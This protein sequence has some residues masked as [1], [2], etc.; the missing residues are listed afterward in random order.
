MA[1]ILFTLGLTVVLLGAGVWVGVALGFSGIIGLAHVLGIDRAVHIAGTVVWEQNTSFVLVAIPMFIFMGEL[2]FQSGVMSKVYLRAATVVSGIPGALLQ[3]NIAAC[4]IF[5]A[6][7]GSSVASAATIGSVGYPEISKRGYDKPI[8][9]GSIAAG[10]TLGILIPPSII[11]IV[12]GSL[13]EVSVG[14]LFLAGVIPGLALAA[15]YSAYIA[16]RCLIDPALAPREGRMGMVERLRAMLGLWQMALL[17]VVVIGGI[18]GGIASPTE[19]AALGASLAILIAVVSG[20]L[21]VGAVWRAGLATVRQTSMIL[22]VI[23]TAKTLA[24]TLIYFRVPSAVVAWIGAAGMTSGDIFLAVVVIYLILGMFVD[25]IAMMV[26]T[27]PFIGPIMAAAQM[28]PIWMG[29]VICILI[30]VGLLT[31]PVGL[32]LYV[33]QGVTNEPMRDVIVGSLPFILLQCA[34]IA[35]LYWWPALALH[36]PSAMS[37]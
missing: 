26:I 16:V 1:P 30:E 37:G 22:F 31:P 36:L 28:D 33:L 29:V 17:V 34:M 6:C 20:G 10:G 35:A 18:Y 19:V 25:G 13:A 14:K 8:A 2:L 21:S 23:F 12:Y 11:F 7:S 15:L 5:A 3:A 24:M 27:I 4:T 32:N 9:L